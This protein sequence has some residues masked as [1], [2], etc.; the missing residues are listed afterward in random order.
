[1][2]LEQNMLPNRP[3]LMGIQQTMQQEHY[4]ERR[5]SLYNKYKILE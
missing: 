4:P 5:P 2:L 1:M 3:V